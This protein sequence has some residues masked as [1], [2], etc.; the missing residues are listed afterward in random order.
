MNIHEGKGSVAFISVFTVCQHT[1][2]W[3]SRMKRVNWWR[4]MLHKIRQ[5]KYTDLI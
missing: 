5:K 2:L 4:N 1:G 3:L